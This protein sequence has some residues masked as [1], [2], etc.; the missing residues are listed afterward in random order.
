MQFTISRLL[1]S[2]EWESHLSRYSAI[3][4]IFGDFIS[5]IEKGETI[6]ILE[7][8]TIIALLKNGGIV[9]IGYKY[10]DLNS[11]LRK[12]NEQTHP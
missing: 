8:G 3:E 12:F 10:S 2:G 5:D 6:I 1:T 11:V 7:E 9:Q 4:D